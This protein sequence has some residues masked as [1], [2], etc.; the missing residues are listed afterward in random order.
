[1]NEKEEFFKFA[2][3][4]KDAEIEGKKFYDYFEYNELNLW[5]FCIVGIC[6]EMEQ[7]RKNVPIPK[8]ELHLRTKVFPKIEFFLDLTLAVKSKIVNFGQKIE[9]KPWV[10]VTM[11]RYWKKT[12]NPEEREYKKTDD[13]FGNVIEEVEK[14][15]KGI[16][17]T[18]EM[19]VMQ[20]KSLEPVINLL[21]KRISSKVPYIPIEAF[22]SFK[23][24][25]E[26]MKA[27]KHFR[28][29]WDFLKDNPEFIKAISKKNEKLG[30]RLHNY[31]SYYFQ[32]VL[33]R[34]VKLL[35]I[36]RNFIRKINP[37]IIILQNERGGWEQTLIYAA[38]ERK[39]KT[40]AL[41]H[42]VVYKLHE[43]YFQVKEEKENKTYPD[44]FCVY[45]PE[46][47]K[48]LV[49]ELK[50]FPERIKVI[51]Q[52]RYD[53]INQYN[54]EIS[55]KYLQKNYGLEADKKI[56]LIATQ[57]LEEKIRIRYFKDLVESLKD[58]SDIQVIIKPHPAE[59]DIK[60]YE[61]ILKI[62]GVEAIILPKK[63]D[64]FLALA[65]CDI[66]STFSSTV[67]LEALMFRKPVFTVNTGKE[68][69]T[70][71]WIKENA[72]LEFDSSEKTKKFLKEFL[73]KP[74]KFEGLIK[75]GKEFLKKYYYK[76]DGK[77]SYR[78]VNL[79]EKNEND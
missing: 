79:A 73:N 65:A 1:M 11:D 7:F 55:K 53:R 19:P 63:E 52:P 36:S 76:L 12:Y 75:K 72:A 48:T 54:K 8:K 15:G 62:Y 5:W 45:G 9:E 51:G 3:S 66:F 18:G 38:K 14:K 60:S 68:Y 13:F 31:F 69:G 41:Q 21:D 61:E 23:A 64:T 35:E 39:I 71:P 40:I 59:K 42:G 10:F 56:L 32:A 43:G 2:Y 37:R 58:L 49:N 33:P 50:Y 26:Y 6:Q 20:N 77:A 34:K 29:V 47:K 27:K 28:K 57:P 46:V 16:I 4:L 25:H 70:L 67:A 30:E 44:I 74:E 78:L 24:M 22:W 17:M